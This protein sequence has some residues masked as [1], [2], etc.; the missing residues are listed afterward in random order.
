MKSKGS[1]TIMSLYFSIRPWLQFLFSLGQ[2]VAIFIRLL[3]KDIVY[4]TIV[5]LP[6]ILVQSA[7]D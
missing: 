6:L 1:K 7:G 5:R 2:I 3:Y 4:N